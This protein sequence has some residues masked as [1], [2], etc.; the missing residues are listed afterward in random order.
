MLLENPG[1]KLYND[2]FGQENDPA[3]KLLQYIAAC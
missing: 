1:D 2:V 3:V